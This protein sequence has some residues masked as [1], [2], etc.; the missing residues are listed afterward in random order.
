M[1]KIKNKLIGMAL[2]FLFLVGLILVFRNQLTSIWL[3]WAT[4]QHPK[5][6]AQEMKRNLK[7]KTSFDIS[8]APP[9]SAETNLE[10]QMENQNYPV[11]G[12]LSI[13]SVKINLP[14]FNGDGYYIMFHGAGTMK[15][16]QKMGEGNY[17]LASHHIADKDGFSGAKLL[18]SPLLKVEIGEMVYLTDKSNIYEYK[19]NRIE[20]YWLYTKGDII[21]DERGKKEITLTTCE[22][23]SDY[24]RI[25]QG[26]LVKIEKFSNTL[27][28]QYGFDAQYHQYKW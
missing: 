8:T 24:R 17:A 16:D 5:I 3:T 13:P 7:K 4:N 14:V 19:V 1:K 23:H 21:L 25:V 20:K 2:I 27:A 11:I 6:S 28:H 12:D 10:A 9:I 18:F 26:K 15:P 22:Y